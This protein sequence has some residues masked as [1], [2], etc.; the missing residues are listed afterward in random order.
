MIFPIILFILL[1]SQVYWARRIYGALR[2]WIP[3]TGARRAA[4]LS[5]LALYLLMLAHKAGIL[6]KR[7]T[8]VTLTPASL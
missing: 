6:V 3:G 8:P 4:G 5:L 7:H 2:R 1:L